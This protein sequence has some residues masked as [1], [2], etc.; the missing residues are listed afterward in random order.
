M[1]PQCWLIVVGDVVAR[2][3]ARAGWHRLPLAP[4]RDGRPAAGARIAVIRTH[5]PDF[6]ARAAVI[7]TADV[8]EVA[9]D[10]LVIR[11]RVVAPAGHEPTL[12][13]VHPRIAAGWTDERLEALIG[14][15]IPLPPADHAHMEDLLM[16]RA[17]AYGPAPKRRAHARPNTPGRRRLLSARLVA[18]KAH[19]LR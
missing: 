4:S 13:E 11:H 14:E 16:E 7:G 10:S 5:R 12:A 19:G 9:S 18:R 2:D 3:L 15:A 1:D 6:V 17:L 8:H